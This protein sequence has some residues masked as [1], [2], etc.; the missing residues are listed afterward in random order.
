[1]SRRQLALDDE[2]RASGLTAILGLGSAPG[3]TNLLARAAVER[4][5]APPVAL[6]I[7]AA[8]RDPAAADH[9]FPA[10]YSVQ[11]LLDE[12]RMQ[13]MV[14]ADGELREVAP[15]SGGPSGPFPSRS[16]ARSASTRCT[17]S[18]RR[19]RAPIRACARRASGS[20]WRRG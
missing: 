15:L 4:L 20:A 13:P 3:K 11:T 10:P 7:W 12:L 8:S 6:E 17:P 19:C 2:F 18:W 1:M 5:G 16:G 9:P 14:V